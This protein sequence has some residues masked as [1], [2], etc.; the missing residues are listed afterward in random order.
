E[1]GPP[2]TNNQAAWV[3]LASEVAKKLDLPMVPAPDSLAG[4]DFAFYQE[5]LSGAFIQ[6]GT[7]VGPMQ[8]NPCF[9]VNPKTFEA[10]IP[11]GYE[12][13]LAALARLA[14]EGGVSRD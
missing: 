14:H 12:L 11:F 4:E 8:H 2:A 7:G 9:A 6:I 5:K 3:E 10:S 13:A 1:Q